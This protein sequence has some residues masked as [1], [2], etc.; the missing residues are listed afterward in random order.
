M[1]TFQKENGQNTIISFELLE[2][3]IIGISFQYHTYPYPINRILNDDKTLKLDKTKL[4][5]L[6]LASTILN[7]AIKIV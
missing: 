2:A 1:V 7:R 5:A 3:E 4:V 6:P